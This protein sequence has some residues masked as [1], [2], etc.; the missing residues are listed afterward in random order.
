MSLVIVLSHILSKIFLRKENL[1]KL[2]LRSL[3]NVVL[4]EQSAIRSDVG[5]HFDDPSVSRLFPIDD[6]K[7][8]EVL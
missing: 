1:P 3:E 5:R 8:T 6:Y 7:V 2:F 4:R